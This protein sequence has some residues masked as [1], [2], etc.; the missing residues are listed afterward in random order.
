MLI[1]PRSPCSPAARVG[2]SLVT[3]VAAHQLPRHGEIPG[4]LPDRR[5]LTAEFMNPVELLDAPLSLGER[6]VPSRGHRRRNRQRF[7]ASWLGDCRGPRLVAGHGV[8][9]PS[10]IG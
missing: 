6:G 10:W 5:P 9:P 4:D 2:A 1:H 3:E 7:L 8:A